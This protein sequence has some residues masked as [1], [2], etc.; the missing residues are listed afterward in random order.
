M[1]R[2]KTRTQI[3]PYI[4]NDVLDYW[5]REYP[6]LAHEFCNRAMKLASNSH[7]FF[8]YVFFNNFHRSEQVPDVLLVD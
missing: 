3:H 7:E 4:D 2:L 1:S 5:Q 6:N 8:D